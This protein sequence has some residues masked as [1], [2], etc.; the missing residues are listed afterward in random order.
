MQL[1]LPVP[2]W[3]RSRYS[4]NGFSAGAPPQLDCSK[5][6]V[7]AT[8]CPRRS[9]LQ[10]AL[11][12]VAAGTCSVLEHGFLTRVERP[13]RLPRADRQR[14]DRASQ[15]VVYRDADYGPLLVELDGRLFHDSA[16][17]RDADLE[18][19]LDAA[20]DGRGSLRLGW[21][22]VFGRPCATAAKLAAIMRSRG[23]AV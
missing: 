3:R 14:P 4:R 19:D 12:D 16:T 5:H 7:V 15:G 13:H 21:G 1:S 8:A 22:Q 9:W 2:T 11:A 6:S 18:R 20:V 17:A 10:G 23:I